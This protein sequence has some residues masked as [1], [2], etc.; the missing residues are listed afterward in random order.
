M[1]NLILLDE[2][3]FSLLNIKNAGFNILVLFKKLSS[4]TFFFLINKGQSKLQAPT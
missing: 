3:K 1:C 4:N 2:I